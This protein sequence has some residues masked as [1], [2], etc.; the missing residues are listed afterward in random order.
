[1][2][3]DCE[4]D[5]GGRALEGFDDADLRQELGRIG[6]DDGGAEY[7][8]RCCVGDNFGEAV[9]FA[10]RLRLADGAPGDFADHY[11]VALF[12]GLFLCEAEACDLR[13]AVDGAR[14]VRVF[15]RLGVPARGH[16]RGDHPLGEGDVGEQKFSGD[17]ADRIDAGGA[18]LHLIVDLDEA[19]LVQFDACGLEAK[20]VRVGLHPDAEQHFVAFE[21]GVGSGCVVLDD[22]AVAAGF[23]PADGGAG[24]VVDALLLEGPLKL[25]G[26]VFVF[27]RHEVG[28]HLED[29][30]F[31]AVCAVE[32][33]ELCADGAA[34]DDADGL[35]DFTRL[36]RLAAGDDLFAIDLE[37]GQAA[38]TGAGCDHDAAAC[39][40]RA[41]VDLDRRCAR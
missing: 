38:G 34:A 3:V 21:L 30:D 33:G 2:G 17:V 31:G 9:I 11:F 10:D 39:E 24:D 7:V 12:T 28:Q 18:G 16:L 5:F 25:N 14:H 23:S 35:R 15:E 36:E 27:G 6:A 40:H 4:A 1:M 22:H 29:G 37:A 13:L 32:V 20:V 26:D 19:V 8:A 41:V